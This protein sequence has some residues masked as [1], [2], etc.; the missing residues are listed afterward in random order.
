MRNLKHKFHAI[1][2]EFD[3][4][5]FSSKK[6]ANYYL[7]LKELKESGEILFFL[8]QVPLFLSGKTKYVIDFVEFWSNG[9]ILF[10]E[11]KGFWTEM[12]KLKLK[13][14]EAIYPFKVNIV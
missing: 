14:T 1:Q 10:T 7:K 11:V 5:K 9:D 8:R 3:G 2:T 13:Q 12:A 6:E 4:I